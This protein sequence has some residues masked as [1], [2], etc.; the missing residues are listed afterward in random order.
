MRILGCGYST[1]RLSLFLSKA[2]ETV[3]FLTLVVTTLIYTQLFNDHFLIKFGVVLIFAGGAVAIWL[4][5][6]TL[7]QY[8]IIPA[9]HLLFAGGFF[10]LISALSL[11]RAENFGCGLEKLFFQALMFSLC[12]ATASHCRRIGAVRKLTCWVAL[13]GLIVSTLGL[14]QY[15]GIQF[16][17]LP[18]VYDGEPLSTLGNPNFVAHYLELVI[19]FVGAILLFARMTNGLRTFLFVSFLVMLGHMILI[20]SRAGWLATAVALLLLVVVWWKKSLG[21]RRRRLVVSFA[22]VFAIVIT[23]VVISTVWDQGGSSS[24]WDRI[25]A[26]WD[27]LLSLNDESDFSRSMRLLIWSDTLNLIED[28]LFLG[29]GPG[30]FPFFLPASGSVTGHREWRELMD[31]LTHVPYHAHNEYLEIWAEVGFFGLVMWLALMVFLLG[32][33]WRVVCSLIKEEDCLGNQFV[34][35]AGTG[36]ICSI[37]AGLIHAVFSFNFQDAVASVHFWVFA[38]I[39]VA[40]SVREGNHKTLCSSVCRWVLGNTALIVLLAGCYLGLCVLLG[41]Y[42]YSRGWKEFKSGRPNRAILEFRSAVDWRGHE[43][44]HT[45]ML[46]KVALIQNR[47]DEAEGALYQSL[48]SHPNNARVLRLLG[49]VM[50]RKEKHH[51]AVSFLERAVKLDPLNANGYSVRALAYRNTGDHEKAV[52]SRRQALSFRPEDAILMMN[53]GIELLAGG[54]PEEAVDVF[55]KA[56]DLGSFEPVITGNRGAALLQLGRFN[57]AEAAFRQAISTDFQNRIQWQY[58]LA[59]VLVR[60]GRKDEAVTV[61]RNAA[62]TAPNDRRIASMLKEFSNQ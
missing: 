11:A 8:I 16:V 15:N 60:T 58:N 57:E 33:G 62:Q 17:P 43:F 29:V 6:A 41:D 19:P 49:E 38:G 40:A 55:E 28:Y 48:S 25:V 44:R 39:L 23:M 35:A 34:L 54:E 61:L 37:A 50:L 18:N 4:V 26:N 1:E 56:G 45:H 7:E 10:L 9:R 47:L 13:V 30:N 46:G 31:T 3:L 59:Q 22:S 12:I 20:E 27:R 36:S 24:A 21:S 32:T 42:Y 52:D 5:I 2:F 14:L 51:E 53:L